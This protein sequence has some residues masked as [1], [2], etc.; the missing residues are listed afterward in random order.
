MHFRHAKQK[1][2]QMKRV[3]MYRGQHKQK[4]SKLDKLGWL[5]RSL[6]LALLSALHLP[7]SASVASCVVFGV[8]DSSF[9][10]EVCRATPSTVADGG[11]EW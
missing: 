3:N 7:N 2:E 6:R 11:G 9:N 10:T 5:S 8:L 4:E 1:R